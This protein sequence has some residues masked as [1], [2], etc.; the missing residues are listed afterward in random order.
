LRKSIDLL[1]INEN[2][3]RLG[4]DQ[5]ADQSKDGTFSGT[6]FPQDDAELAA[7]KTTRER[8]KDD[9]ASIGH[10]DAIE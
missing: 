5:P 2:S 6:A 7:A 10:A 3:A 9:A 4:S 1:S 8:I